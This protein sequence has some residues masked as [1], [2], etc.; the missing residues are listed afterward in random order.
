MDRLKG[1]L[2]DGFCPRYCPEYSLEQK[3]RIA[4]RQKQP[5][6]NAIPM[7]CFC[8]LPLSLIR[9][10]LDEY[11]C[12]GIGMT[13]SWGLANG[14]AP[15]IYTHSKAKTRPSLARLTGGSHSVPA[16]V[17]RDLNYLASYTKPFQG[18]AWRKDEVRHR[19][20]FY[21]EREWRYVP[22]VHGKQPLFL[23]W[24]DYS[25]KSKRE[26]LHGI[27]KKE[28]S[29]E[30]TPDD[31]SYLILKYEK[32]EANVLRLHDFVMQLYGRRY[33]RKNAVLVTTTIMTDDCIKEDI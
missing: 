27:L 24:N 28:H 26:A 10:H 31:V 8:D 33:G 17:A 4:A 23:N 25:N 32:D 1:I 20:P 19:V 7:V 18:P 9:K 22:T 15:V 30:A 3:D 13:K 16:D 2:R 11:G 29:I 14:I 6:S 5:P 12:F 21:D